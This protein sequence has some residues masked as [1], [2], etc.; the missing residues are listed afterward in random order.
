MSQKKF[1][2]SQFRRPFSQPKRNN[3]SKI[4]KDFELV[5]NIQTVKLNVATIMKIDKRLN[6]KSLGKIDRVF[7][8]KVD[9]L[10]KVLSHRFQNTLFLIF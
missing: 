2:F 8:V 7:L 5:K 9:T 10:R 6:L 3:V 1:S 4:V